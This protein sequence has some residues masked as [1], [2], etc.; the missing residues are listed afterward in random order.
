M[1]NKVISKRKRNNK[2]KEKE[3][4]F[5]QVF[6]VYIFSTNYYY[7]KF[8]SQQVVSAEELV[9]TGIVDL[10]EFS[11]TNLSQGQT[12]SVKITFS[13]KYKDHIKPGDTLTFPMPRG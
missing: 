10:F 1:E 11:D 9:G 2:K 3:D 6:K 12:T 5:E 8:Y 7:W 4:H 13:E